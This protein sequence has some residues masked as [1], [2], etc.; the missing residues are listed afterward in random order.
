MQA[1]QMMKDRGDKD[2]T[3]YMYAFFMARLSTELL[4]YINP[5]EAT[6]ILQSPATTT[7]FIERIWRL[8][9]QL[10]EDIWAGEWERYKAGSRKGETKIQKAV[11]D[12][13]PWAK[14][15]NRHK[16]VKDILTYHYRE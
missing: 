6:R 11:Y 2:E 8:M 10:G 14:A 15:I 3:Y 4:G 1:A 9:D 5:W 16:Y 7:T 12:V 13:V